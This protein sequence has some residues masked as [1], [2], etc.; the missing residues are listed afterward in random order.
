M[1]ENLG[2]FGM[3]FIIFNKVLNFPS[4]NSIRKDLHAYKIYCTI[5]I[6]KFKGFTKKKIYRRITLKNLNTFQGVYITLNYLY[7]YIGPYLLCT[8]N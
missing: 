3:N 7:I 5:L 4:V 6:V 1:I 2:R 8:Y